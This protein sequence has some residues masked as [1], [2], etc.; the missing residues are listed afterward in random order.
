MATPIQQMI[1]EL[2]KFGNLHGSNIAKIFLEIEEEFL[3]DA[4]MHSLDEDGHTGDWKV[5]FVNNYYDKIS[6]QHG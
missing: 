2:N 1:V 4:M 3:K 5:G 6:K